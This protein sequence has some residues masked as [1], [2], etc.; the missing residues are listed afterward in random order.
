MVST[1]TCRCAPARTTRQPAR[2]RE[3]ARGAAARRQRRWQRALAAHPLTA[4]RRVRPSRAAVWRNRS[5]STGLYGK[6]PIQAA[7]EGARAPPA[8]GASALP[9]S[10]ASATVASSAQP[11]AA[12]AGAAALRA[13]RH[14]GGSVGIGRRK[15]TRCKRAPRWRGRCGCSRG[16]RCRGGRGRAGAV[17]AGAAGA[18]QSAGRARWCSPREHEQK[19]RRS[20]EQRRGRHRTHDWCVCPRPAPG[21][22]PL[23]PRPG[24]LLS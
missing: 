23:A 13:C 9:T 6:P 2:G 20:A 10:S 15:R 18:G 4:Q 19:E 7:A 17:E 24:R 22:T 16:R 21:W 11:K 3:P 8:A 12:A 5:S 1:N 14:A